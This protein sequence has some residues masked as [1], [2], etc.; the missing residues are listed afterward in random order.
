MARAAA[1]GGSSG[2]S[3]SSGALDVHHP[4]ERAVA[5]L[6]Q[7]EPA[8]RALPL[9]LRLLVRVEPQRLRVEG[10]LEHLR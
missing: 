3:G 4:A 2:S 7:R 5:L 1:E 6:Q 8:R 10:A 9:R